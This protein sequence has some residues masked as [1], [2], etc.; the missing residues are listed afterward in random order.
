MDLNQKAR[1][2]SKKSIR[3]MRA[4][5]PKRVED[6][7][8]TLQN[9][10]RAFNSSMGIIE[11][12][13]EGIWK[14]YRANPDRQK[15]IIDTNKATGVLRDFIAGKVFLTDKMFQPLGDFFWGKNIFG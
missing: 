7:K 4:A 14:T 15:G 3:Q 13:I 8:V 11:R 10:I 5:T 6:P 1:V 12:V 2:S 9:A